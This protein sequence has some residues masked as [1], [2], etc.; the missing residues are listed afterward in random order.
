MDTKPDPKSLDVALSGSISLNSTVDETKYSIP[1]TPA[2]TT[3]ARDRAA[4]PERLFRACDTKHS[5][6]R[7]RIQVPESPLICTNQVDEVARTPTEQRTVFLDRPGNILAPANDSEEMRLGPLDAPLSAPPCHTMCGS[8][9]S[10]SFAQESVPVFVRANSEVSSQE[11]LKQRKVLNCSYR[12]AQPPGSAS[13]IRGLNTDNAHSSKSPYKRGCRDAVHPSPL[14]RSASIESTSSSS[15]CG[16]G[17][18]SPDWRSPHS[19]YKRGTRGAT[20]VVTLST[21][22]SAEASPSSKTPLG[23]GASPKCDVTHSLRNLHHKFET[24]LADLRVGPPAATVHVATLLETRRVEVAEQISPG[25]SRWMPNIP[26][27]TVC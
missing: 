21:C 9:K 17:G 11:L 18:A 15:F 8:N 25:A 22:S 20:P 2:T 13:L 27:A 1:H 19:P 12:S 4:A 16:T 5:Q 3:V 26:S 23:L 7:P 6:A 14:R 24:S 10:G